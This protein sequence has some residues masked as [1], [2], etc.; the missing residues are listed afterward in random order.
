[1]LNH[2]VSW[3][4]VRPHLPLTLCQFLN[5]FDVCVWIDCLT[6]GHHI[7]QNHSINV[8]KDLSGRRNCLELLFSWWLRMMPLHWLPFHLYLIRVSPGFVT[9]DDLRQK[10]LPSASKCSNNSE[11]MAF[12]W[13]LCSVVRPR[14]THLA[15]TFEYPKALIIA[16]A[17]PLLAE[18][19]MAYCQLVMHRSTWIIPSARCNVSGLVAVAGRP[20]RAR[21]RVSVSPLPEAVTLWTQRPTVLLLTAQLPY[22]AHNR[23]WMFP[24]L[25]F[26]PTKN[27]ITAHCL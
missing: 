19:C 18:S 24:T 14:G 8:P 9:C 17:L 22:T 4:P 23:L 2:I 26:S 16:I 10:G 25:S 5:G 13:R 12:L 3:I 27:S 21:S 1:M 20:D 11:Q 7:H 6:S 15:H